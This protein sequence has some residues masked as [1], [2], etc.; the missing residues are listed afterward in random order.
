M[1]CGNI[2]GKIADVATLGAYGAVTGGGFDILGKGEAKDQ[3]NQAMQNQ[4][5]MLNKSLTAEERMFAKGLSYADPYF[6]ASV[7]ALPQLMAYSGYKATP[8]KAADG[9]V[10]PNKYTYEYAGTEASPLYQ[11]QK[12]Q[13]EKDLN[14]RLGLLGRRNSSYG[15]NTFKDFYSGLNANE[16]ARQEN[17]LLNLMKIGQGSAGT[18]TAAST[19][20]GD[21]EAALYGNYGNN[22]T[23]LY[24]AQ[25]ALATSY[26]P[27]NVGT[28]VLRTLAGLK[29]AG[30]KG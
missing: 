5:D 21:A 7:A 11:W 14:S 2:F 10:I 16:A 23:N 19:H 4:Q 6:D 9:T 30:A 15:L 17:S 26:S 13:G 18:A 22:M 25:G 20:L 1:G 29:G 8:Y 12:T 27:F 3:M 28:S 24:G